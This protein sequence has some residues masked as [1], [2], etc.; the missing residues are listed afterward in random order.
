MRSNC[1]RRAWPGWALGLLVSTIALGSC[2]SQSQS[3]ADWD[4]RTE[5][6]TQWIARAG[7]ESLGATNV[8]CGEL[9][10]LREA[11]GVTRPSGAVTVGCWTWDSGDPD[12]L[13]DEV[14]MTISDIAE[15]GSAMVN[16]YAECAARRSLDLS[17]IPGSCTGLV[18]RKGRGRHL[19][20]H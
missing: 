14:A 11:T 17:F 5:A 9:H 3:Q 10:A 13:V 6:V 2:S 20:P 19:H 12:A 4:T 15:P 1:T 18:D 7:I 8:P 16:V